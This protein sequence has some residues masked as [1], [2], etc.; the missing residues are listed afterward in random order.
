MAGISSKALNFGNPDNKF[1][2]NGKEKQEKEF[3]DGS[4][5][6][7]LDYG[8]RMYDNQIG[9]FFTQDR[10]TEK[11]YALNPYQYAAN[12]PMLFIDN[13][14]DSLIVNGMPGNTTAVN[15]YESQV[16]TGLGGFYTLGKST[17]GKYVLNATGQEGTM[18]VEQQAF[19][20]T[21]NETI[22]N[23]ADVTFTV[24]D[25]NDAM[26]QNVKIGDCGCY[27]GSPVTNHTID[28]SDAGQFGSTGYI[29]TQGIIGH[30]TKE[31]FEIQTKGLTTAAQI[32]N[33]HNVSAIGAENAINGN[34]RILPAP[35]VPDFVGNTLTLNLNVSTGIGRTTYPAT[36]TATFTN[37]QVTNVSGNT[38]PPPLKNLFP[39]VAPPKFRKI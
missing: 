11:Y 15:T 19:Y 23:G 6:Q 7:W 26:S 12:N 18:S 35:G 22:S 9:R 14:G 25:G 17:T 3:A 1:E 13:N 8:A 28:V 2:Y 30:E 38:K 27:A 24:I 16:N 33:A 31:G 32:N 5:L 34:T 4:G 20:D 21:M 10:F 36:V 29:T 39:P 37:G